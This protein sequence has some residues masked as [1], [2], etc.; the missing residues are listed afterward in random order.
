VQQDRCWL[1][2]GLHE[3]EA[4]PGRWL[5]LVPAKLGFTF[6]HES[7]EV[8]YLHE[9]RPEAWPDATR[10]LGRETTTLAHRLLL[11]AAALG[12][13]AFPA[14]R[15]R[16]RRRA[17]AAAAVVQGALLASAAA[18]GALAFAGA[19]P[20]FWPLA[21]FAA[22]VPW[23]PVPGRPARRPA[24]ELAL[25]LL[26]TTIAAHAVFFGEDRYHVVVTPVLALL[27]A[28]ALRPS[29]GSSARA[30]DVVDAPT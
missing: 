12:G 23:L 21:L 24:M 11:S 8:E 10:A 18:L 2:Y 25:G 14:L 28:A 29:Q 13:I 26:A 16:P 7:F 27:A 20:S 15:R 5:G 4:H 1:A 9:A 6:D 19:S 17:T 22:V 3:I 30:V